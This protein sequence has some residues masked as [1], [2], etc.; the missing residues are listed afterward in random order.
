MRIALICGLMLCYLSFE[1]GRFAGVLAVQASGPIP[2]CI[3]S[4]KLYGTFHGPAK[5]RKRHPRPRIAEPDAIPARGL[6]TL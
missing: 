5:G 3:V 2:P 1:A 4:P 6:V